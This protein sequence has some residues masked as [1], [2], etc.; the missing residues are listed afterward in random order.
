VSPEPGTQVRPRPVAHC[1]RWGGITS[2]TIHRFK[3]LEADGVILI[4]DELEPMEIG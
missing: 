2:E 1:A 4:L 3:G